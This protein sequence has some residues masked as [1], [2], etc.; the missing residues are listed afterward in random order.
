MAK[1]TPKENFM[2][3]VGGGHPEY[4]PYYTMV[5][6][7][8]LGEAADVMLNPAVF[9]ETHFMDGG[10]D[11]WGVP[12][13]AT[14]GTAQATMP[15]TRI[16]ILPEIDEW[17]NV[18]KH[19][20]VAKPNEIDWE[21]VYQDGLKMFG[22]DRTQTALKSGPS[23]MPFQQLVAMMGF[24]GGLMALYEDPDEVL[25]MLHYMVDFLEP[26]FTKYIDVYKP[27]L[28]YM[29]DDTCAKNAPFF[30]MDIYRKVFKPIYERLAKPAN[31]RGIPIVFHNCGFIEPQIDDMYDFGVRLIEPTQDTNDLLKLKEKYKGK[32][33]FIG[34]WEW[35]NQMPKNYPEYDE[36]ELRQGVRD[37]MD[38]FAPGGGYGIITWPL[39]YDGDPVL[40][41]VKRI[42]R[43]ECHWYGRKIYGYKD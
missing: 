4:V 37:A 26:Y 20:N 6:E 40:P 16:N 39:S 41:E 33:G 31:D 8:Y 10:K 28:W 29:L 24:E 17:R 18:V 21:K 43:D 2:K 5:G 1:I 36:E 27:D 19:P 9:G 7:P 25:N 11:M 30:S 34:G 38:K 22:V 35:Q 23:F 13:R 14:E 15:D 3:I 12:H 32:I 42:L